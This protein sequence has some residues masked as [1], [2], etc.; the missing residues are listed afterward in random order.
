MLHASDSGALGALVSCAGGSVR[1]AAVAAIHGPRRGSSG[2]LCG[3]ITGR[4]FGFR[5]RSGT[6]D[7]AAPPFLQV[8]PAIESVIAALNGG[9]AQF[10]LEKSFCCYSL[11]GSRVRGHVREL[12]DAVMRLRFEPSSNLNTSAGKIQ[13]RKR[14]FGYRLRFSRR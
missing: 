13:L 5:R 9:L 4:S 8:S 10:V 2:V 12:R 14:I 11:F 1:S 3:V 7:A 6:G